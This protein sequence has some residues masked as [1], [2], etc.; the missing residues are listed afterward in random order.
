MDEKLCFNFFIIKF[1]TIEKENI[2]FNTNRNARRRWKKDW[3]FVYTWMVKA[4]EKK[5]TYTYIHTKR[6][7][8]N[9]LKKS[10]EILWIFFSFLPNS[11]AILFV[12]WFGTQELGYE[13]V[14]MIP[15]GI[16]A[17]V[18]FVFMENESNPWF[19]ELNEDVN[20]LISTADGINCV[21]GCVYSMHCTIPFSNARS[22]HFRVHSTIFSYPFFCCY[23][24][25]D[26]ST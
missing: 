22:C 8:T 26:S 6:N 5:H 2:R 1:L 23:I 11:N 4:E 16:F 18:S 19:G 7:C 17:K 24:I 12:A 14:L 15:F 9:V 20:V 3:V 21:C 13:H 25:H 10:R